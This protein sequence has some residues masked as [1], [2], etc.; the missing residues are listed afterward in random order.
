MGTSYLQIIPCSKRNKFEKANEC[1]EEK[2]PFFFVVKKGTFE[3]EK[4]KIE[5]QEN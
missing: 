2:K 3:S 5:K 4:L 1:I